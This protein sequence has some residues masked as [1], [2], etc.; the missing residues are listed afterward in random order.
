[1]DNA[2]GFACLKDTCEWMCSEDYKE[3]MK[4]EYIQ[5]KMRYEK[6]K[7]F[8]NRIEAA[9]IMGREQPKHDCPVYLLRDQ[10]SVMGSY[11]SI[12]EKRMIIEGIEII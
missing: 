2:M 12:L 11:L 4:A 5:T 10:Q 7:D 6:L 3:R 1:M 9:E 8:C